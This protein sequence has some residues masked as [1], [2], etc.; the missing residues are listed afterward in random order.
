MRTQL[1]HK[2]TLPTFVYPHEAL[3][4]QGL[5]SIPLHCAAIAALFW[6]CRLSVHNTSQAIRAKRTTVTWACTAHGHEPASSLDPCWTLPPKLPGP[7]PP[8]PCTQPRPHP[9]PCLVPALPLPPTDSALSP[10]LERLRPSFTNPCNNLY[11]PH[12]PASA[13]LHL[14][15]ALEDFMSSLPNCLPRNRLPSLAADSKRVRS[16]RVC[17][18]YMYFYTGIS[19]D[20]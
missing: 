1:L 20:M 17:L 10:I 16:T 8:H 15:P 12:W 6:H 7:P 19:R 14:T 2:L 5:R 3:H 9:Q 11:Q 18:V 13:H 4:F